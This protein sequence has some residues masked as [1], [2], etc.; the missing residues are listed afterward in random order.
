MTIFQK[1]RIKCQQ[2]KLRESQLSEKKRERSYLKCAGGEEI[3][4]N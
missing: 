2:L 1:G 4:F 3:I